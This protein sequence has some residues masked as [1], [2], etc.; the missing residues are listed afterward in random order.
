V[1]RDP[2]SL[3]TNALD[4]DRRALA[5]VLSIVESGE[6]AALDVLAQ[7]Y[8]RT[9]NAHV[10]GITGAPGAGKSTLTDR[11]I[12]HGRQSGEVA[13]LAVDPSSPFSGGSIMG[14]RVRMQ[15]H[16]SDKGVFVRSMASRGHLGGLSVAAPKAIA[17]LDAVG[18]PIVLVETVGVGQAE[19]E[20]AGKTDTAVVVVNPRWGDGIQAAKAG[21]LEIGQIFAINKSD[22]AG[23]DETAADL[24]QMLR[25]GEAQ[26]WEVPIIKT[27]ATTGEGTDELWAAIARHKAYLTD[28]GVLEADRSKRATDEFIA[29]LRIEIGQRADDVDHA[30]AEAAVVSRSLDPWSAAKQ[31]SRHGVD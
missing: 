14:D 4:G 31:V 8:P 1:T 29:A 30:D 17:V 9:G 28:S 10:I 7:A 15:A 19:V 26:D 12:A 16:V 3:I 11:L 27:V 22:M 6:P 20:V 24:A 13:V 18:F 23:A 25:M 21:L 5:R 2:D